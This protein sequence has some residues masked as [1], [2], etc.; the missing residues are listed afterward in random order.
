MGTLGAGN[1]GRLFLEFSTKSW[2]E[3]TVSWFTEGKA[4]WCGSLDWLGGDGDKVVNCF[5]MGENAEFMD[6][7]PNEAAVLAHAVSDLDAMYPGTPFSDTFVGGSWHNGLDE[8]FL[9]GVYS[10]PGIGSYP[11]DGSPSAREVLAQQV[12]TNLYFAGEATHNRHAA[13]VAGA[14]DT[15]LRAAGEIDADHDP[16]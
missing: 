16:Q 10:F 1:G 12:G 9:K 7:L 8:E 3:G 13:T 11:T 6:S 2:P 15:G 14:L 4:G 5:T